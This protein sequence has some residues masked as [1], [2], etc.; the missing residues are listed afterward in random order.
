MTAMTACDGR[1]ILRKVAAMNERRVAIAAIVFALVVGLS[2]VVA[3]AAV[4]KTTS[5][6][7]DSATIC[8]ADL[9][10][11]NLP[12][13]SVATEDQGEVGPGPC[14]MY[15]SPRLI[16]QWRAERFSPPLV[17]FD[18]TVVYPDAYAGPGVDL[19]TIARSPDGYCIRAVATA[20]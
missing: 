1:S 18:C 3:A 5:A 12:G 7:D 6:P 15:A 8:L 20:P 16:A 9:R 19:A 14:D 13:L 10:V 2:G 4:L 11:L 17:L